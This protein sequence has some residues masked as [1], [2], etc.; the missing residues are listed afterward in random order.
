M[1]TTMC[2]S[3]LRCVDFAGGKRRLAKTQKHSLVAVHHG[4]LGEARFDHL[5]RFS[6]HAFA[7]RAVEKSGQ[8]VDERCSI[9]DPKQKSVLSREDHLGRAADIG[10]HHGSSERHGLERSQLKRL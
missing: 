4:A 3:A 8:S 1:C 7:V 5:T 2:T 10:V 6:S 9:T